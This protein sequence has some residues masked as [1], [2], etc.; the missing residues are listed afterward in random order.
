MLLKYFKPLITCSEVP[1]SIVASPHDL[2]LK[3]PGLYEFDETFRTT[4][5]TFE[6]PFP[7]SEIFGL[8]CPDH[9][10]TVF[11]G[12][13]TARDSILQYVPLWLKL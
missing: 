7:L 12:I 11:F 6:R 1:L 5:A 3:C 13:S 10:I 2:D 8:P 4:V 9:L